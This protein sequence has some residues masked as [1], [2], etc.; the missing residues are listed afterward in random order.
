MDYKNQTIKEWAVADRPREKMLAKG[1]SSLTDSELIAILIR[2]GSPTD[3]AVSIAKQILAATN[4]NLVELGKWTVPDLMRFKGIG[5]AKAI[6]IVS[7]MELGRRRSMSVAL[8]RPQITS[9]NDVF[10][11]MHPVLAD[12]KHEEFW[13]IYLTRANKI[14]T[15]VCMSSG[16]TSGTVTDI[17]LIMK[18]GLEVLANA[19][20]ICHNH[21]SGNN[22][23]S[24]ADNSLTNKICNAGLLLDMPVL[25]HVIVAGDQYFSYA[26]EGVL[27]A[28]SFS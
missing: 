11:I 9:S 16:G 8:E 26:D 23:P 4:N 27:P 6:A 14:I 7:A 21:P 18:R 19:M 1:L 28:T 17:K 20:I 22:K 5:E 24:S 12:L 2:A 3:S 15:K 10:Q 13:A 25:D